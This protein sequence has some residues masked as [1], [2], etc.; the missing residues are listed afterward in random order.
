MKRVIRV[1]VTIPDGH[2]EAYADVE[3]YDLYETVGDRQYFVRARVAFFE[4]SISGR[5]NG[6]SPDVMVA[7]QQALETWQIERACTHEPG[8]ECQRR[9][10]PAGVFVSGT[11]LE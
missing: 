8:I 6:H 2:D 4:A 7:I 3:Y 1:E 11:V 10:M 9:Q 5:K